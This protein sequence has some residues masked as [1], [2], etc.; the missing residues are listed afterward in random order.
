MALKVVQLSLLGLHLVSIYVSS[1]LAHF[2]ELGRRLPVVFLILSIHFLKLLITGHYVLHSDSL[3]LSGD[4]LLSFL[5]ESCI[6]FSL[7]AEIFIL[8]SE[9]PLLFIEI[10]LPSR[11]HLVANPMGV[12]CFCQV[13]LG[14]PLFSLQLF[15]SVFD[16][17][18]LH[19]FFLLD[20][21]GLELLGWVLD[22]DLLNC[23]YSHLRQLF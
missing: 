23:L 13:L 10:L 17:H 7:S 16:H 8:F 3:P 11:C 12:H 14:F 5:S 2:H 6:E 21:F 20:Q 18:P 9:P 22:L 15:D 19:L 4:V 1:L